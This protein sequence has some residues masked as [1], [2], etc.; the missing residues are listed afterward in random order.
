VSSERVFGTLWARK[1]SSEATKEV[2]GDRVGFVEYSVR[3]LG[4]REKM[5]KRIERANRERSMRRIG[6]LDLGF[7]LCFTPAISLLAFQSQLIV[8]HL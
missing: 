7:G 3:V 8:I 1:C 2:W 5:K 6:D 4:M